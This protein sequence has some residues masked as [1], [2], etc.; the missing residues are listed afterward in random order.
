[1][2]SELRYIR[3]CLAVERQIQIVMSR[4][5]ELGR[6]AGLDDLLK[7]LGCSQQDIGDAHLKPFREEETLRRIRDAARSG[8]EA[9]LW[10]VALCSAVISV[11][12]ALAAWAAVMR[13]SD[14]R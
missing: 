8:R 11:F 3:D 13:G 10:F 7:R 5:S 4:E 9:S 6:K 12:G 1:M 2:G 14:V